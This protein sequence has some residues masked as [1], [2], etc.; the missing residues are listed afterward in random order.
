[1][2]NNGKVRQKVEMTIFCDMASPISF[3]VCDADSKPKVSPPF[4]FW[5]KK[6][7][8]NLKQYYIKFL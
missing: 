2:K 4:D 8:K 5:Q 1:M 7:K 6:N 3:L